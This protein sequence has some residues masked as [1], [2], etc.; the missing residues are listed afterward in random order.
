MRATLS[1]LMLTSILWAACTAQPAPP[2]TVQ[3]PT[4]PAENIL[5]I[6]NW[7][8]YIDPTILQ[9]FETRFNV[10][11]NYVV[12]GSNEEMVENLEA[13]PTAYDIIVPTHYVIPSLRKGGMLAPLNKDNIPNLANLDPA[14]VNPAFDPGNQYC[15]PYQWGTMGIGYNRQTTG[16]DLYGWKDVFEAMPG[17]RIALLDDPRAT[18]GAILLYLGYSPNTTSADEIAAARDLLISHSQDIAAYVPDTGQDLLAEGT[19]DIVFEWSGDIFQLMEENP[20]IRYIIPE[21]GALLWVDNMCIPAQ[22]QHK[23]LAEKFINYILDPQVGARLSNYIRYASPN[24]A[25]LPFIN[26]ADRDNPA[27]YPSPAIRSRLFL[28]TDLS[29]QATLLYEQ[30][31]A[32]VLAAHT[33]SPR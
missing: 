21:E 14:F 22:A 6:Y 30:A 8:T 23:D 29:P 2:P 24:Q 27:I 7:D 18:L 15:A 12:F 13:H 1:L 11:I 31:W 4:V 25:A 33:S 3:T 32:E 5:N 20:D 10:K 16:R 17:S 9:D 28:V 19:V 26:Q